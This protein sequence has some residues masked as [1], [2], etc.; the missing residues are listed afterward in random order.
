[1]SGHQR[2][3]SLS[4]RSQCLCPPPPSLKASL[5]IFLCSI[6]QQKQNFLL[7]PFPLPDSTGLG[8]YSR[9]KSNCIHFLQYEELGNTRQEAAYRTNPTSSH[10]NVA[11]SFI[12]EGKF[13]RDKSAQ[14][15]ISNC[16]LLSNNSTDGFIKKKKKTNKTQP[17]K[18]QHFLQYVI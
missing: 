11:S 5:N 13:L 12:E 4:V 2:C 3:S 15:I 8:S 1:M 17:T 18:Y 14:T 6:L 16:D 9:C 10:P 7:L